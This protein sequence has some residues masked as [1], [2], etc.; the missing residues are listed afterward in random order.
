MAMITTP[1]PF[2]LS[3]IGPFASYR[4]GDLQFRQQNLEDF[5]DTFWKL[6]VVFTG[7]ADKIYCPHH[8]FN[9]STSDI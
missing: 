5:L 8:L 3:E 6:F 2:D 1:C 4:S 9:I 7:P